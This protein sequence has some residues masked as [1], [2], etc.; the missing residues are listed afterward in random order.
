[1]LLV[2]SVVAEEKRLR[3]VDDSVEGE[4]VTWNGPPKGLWGASSVIQW[5]QSSCT[6]Q[7]NQKSRHFLP[8]SQYVWNCY[9]LCLH[10]TADKRIQTIVSS[11]CVS[12]KT[13]DFVESVNII[14]RIL[15]SSPKGLKWCRIYDIIRWMWSVV[16]YSIICVC[17]CVSVFIFLALKHFITACNH[18]QTFLCSY[19]IP[20]ASPVCPTGS[21]QIDLNSRN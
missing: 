12:S 7:Q 20:P 8:I 21:I 2:L 14:E 11:F 1:M 9:I 3:D 17:V 13:L 18:L 4:D 16:F 10:S 15:K 19:I 6:N 5:H